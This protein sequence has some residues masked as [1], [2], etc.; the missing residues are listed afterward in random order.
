M[1]YFLSHQVP[2]F[3][4]LSVCCPFHGGKVDTFFE[5]IPQGRQFTQLVHGLADLG[6]GVV[7]LF[8]GGEATE[9]EAN[10]AM[11]QFVVAAQR[12]QYVGRLQGCL[13]YTS[14]C[15]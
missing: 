8:F 13:L 7:D 1:L 9:G 2:L 10:R 11:R 6:S 4:Q 3:R 15:V 12:T 14:R 5:H